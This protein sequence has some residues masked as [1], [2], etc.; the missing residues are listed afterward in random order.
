MFV[1]NKAAAKLNEVAVLRCLSHCSSECFVWCQEMFDSNDNL[2]ARIKSLLEQ[3]ELRIAKSRASDVTV[4]LQQSLDE[5]SARW[6]ALK[7]RFIEHGNQLTA[8]CDEAQELNDRLNEMM[9]WLNGVEQTLSS[10]QPVS[11]V[12]EN[13][14]LQIQQHHVTTLPHLFHFFLCLPVAAFCTVFTV[15][16]ADLY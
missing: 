1:E 4:Q 7:L 14:H 9:S 13:I 6:D 5:V 11:R 15:V 12:T 3:G 10:L 2:D 16:T 8:A